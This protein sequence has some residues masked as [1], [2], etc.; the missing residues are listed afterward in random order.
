MTATATSASATTA[1]HAGAAALDMPPRLVHGPEECDFYHAVDL[2]RFGFQPGLW[3]LRRGVDAYLGHQPLAG[4]RV[5]EVGSA[6]GFLSFEMESRGAR[7]TAY[8]LSP[9]HDWDVVPY[10]GAVDPRQREGRRQ[11]IARLNNAWWLSHRLRGSRARL[12]HGTAYEVP[13]AL[14]P[15]EV[16]TLGCILLHLRD[17]FLALQ[18]AAAVTSETLIVTE[19]VPGFLRADQFVPPPTD[20][21]EEIGDGFLP[22]MT[23]H[24]NPDTRTP[25]ETWWFLSPRLVSRFLRV[26]G[27]CQT[28]V[29]FHL[30]RYVDGEVWLYT[31]VGRRA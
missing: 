9:A 16:A 23:F 4:R 6:S 12:A 24:P 18:R 30:Q 3:D 11:H 27:F 5:L 19:L 28:R 20:A 31:V 21:P 22:P 25:W 17:P 13:A 26:L 8:D 14:G 15:F 1:R 10:G 29:N 2:P 7:V